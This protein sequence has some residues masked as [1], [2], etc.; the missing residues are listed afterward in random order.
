[1]QKQKI[2]IL[3]ASYS[4]VPLIQAARRLGYYTIATSIPGDYPGFSVADESCCCDIT[5]PEEILQAAR[6]YQID[7]IATCCM[8]VGLRSQ[9]YVASMLGLPGPNWEGAQICTDKSR[10]KQAFQ[11]EK[12]KTAAYAKVYSRDDLEK[13]CETLRFPV[14]IKAVDQM[15]GRGIA[16]CD[17]REALLEAYPSTMSATDKDYCIVEEFLTG[18][19]FGVEAMVEQGRPVYFL[20][21][22]DELHRKNPFFLMGHW[23]PCE[24]LRPYRAQI[25]EQIERVIRA[26]GVVSSPMNFDM[27]LLDGEIYVIEATMRAGATCLPELVGLHFG[28]NYYEMLIRLCM[29]ERVGQYFQRPEGERVPV[30]VKQLEADAA[31]IVEAVIPG[32]A[33]GGDLVD[34]SFNIKRGDTV[35]LMENGRDRIGQVIVKGD[36]M[37]SCEALL[38]EVLERI[39]IKVKVKD[40]N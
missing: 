9:G 29:G 14:I 2:M 31:G 20:P 16:R 28:V 19:M 38:A 7:G 25:Q 26:Y 3:G 40:E 1:M 35:R 22:G 11:Q 15:G 36:T 18:T 10:M 34:L 13:V 6:K 39:Q 12:V 32:T 23:T 4:L 24:E 17:T 33:V 30:I 21:V 8:D 37:E 27:M 5:K